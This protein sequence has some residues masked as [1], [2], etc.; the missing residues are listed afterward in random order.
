MQYDASGG[1]TLV[2]IGFPIDTV[3][4]IADISILLKMF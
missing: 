2:V 3:I 4:G 1:I